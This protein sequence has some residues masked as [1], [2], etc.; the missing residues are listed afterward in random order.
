M[1]FGRRDGVW[2]NEP[3]RWIANEDSL[4]IV[5]D[6]ATYFWRETHYGFV[7]DTGHFLGFP[8]SEAFTA[9]L[10]VQG[11]FQALYGARRVASGVLNVSADRSAWQRST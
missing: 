11:D 3:G 5:T 9:E 10:R 6:K 4:K 2:L 8:T 1:I 7:R